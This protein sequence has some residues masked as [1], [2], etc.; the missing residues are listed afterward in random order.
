MIIENERKENKMDFENKIVTVNLVFLDNRS[1]KWGSKEYV[2]YMSE[3]L[4]K[5]VFDTLYNKEFS[6]VNA[7]GYNYRN[8]TLKMVS[9]SLIKEQNTI[10]NLKEQ[11][12]EIKEVIY[13]RFKYRTFQRENSDKIYIPEIISGISEIAKTAKTIENSFNLFS[14]FNVMDNNAITL[15]SILSS[16]SNLPSNS[17]SD[18]PYYSLG[19]TVDKEKMEKNK[20]E[21]KMNK[22]CRDL[23]FGKVSTEQI[24]MSIYGPAFRCCTGYV[25]FDGKD[26]IDVTDFLL[27][28]DNYCFMLPATEDQV[29]IGDFIYHTGGW[30]R[31]IDAH[32]R[33]ITVENITVHE[34]VE[35]LPT[36][37]MFGFNFYTK[38]FMPFEFGNPNKDN[39]FG[40]MLPL[41]ATS[42]GNNSDDMLMMM[43][44]MNNQYGF[45]FDTSNPMNMYLMMSILGDRTNGNNDTLMMAMLMGQMNKAPHNCNCNNGDN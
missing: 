37:N 13:D 10:K 33:T 18:F 30:C 23:H 8:A 7:K 9:S 32:N 36:K 27:D 29:N 43:M 25:A 6:I 3:E 24:R 19:T 42:N 22:L 41:L 21:N 44:L 2:Y 15:N 4:Y 17:I 45:N 35:I 34:V 20:K 31:V 39:P 1:L 11:F 28:I 38:L 14:D 5:E 40:N 26:Y 16:I 12:V